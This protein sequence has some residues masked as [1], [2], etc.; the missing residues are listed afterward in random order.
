MNK[1]N[2]KIKNSIHLLECFPKESRFYWLLKL[3]LAESEKGLIID[4]FN[5]KKDGI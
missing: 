1:L 5:S 2:I 4:Y 3:P